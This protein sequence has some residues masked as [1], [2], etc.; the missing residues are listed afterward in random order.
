MGSDADIVIWNAGGTRTI[1]AQ[2]HHHA[3]DFNIFEGMVVHGVP[4]I[5]ISR[6]NVVWQ[7]GELNVKAGAGKFVPLEP[8]C[9]YVFAAIP[10]RAEK[11]KPIFVDRVNA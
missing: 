1:S 5:T 4:E 2:T 9:N 6:G 8:F 3:N 11:M 10:A 7:S